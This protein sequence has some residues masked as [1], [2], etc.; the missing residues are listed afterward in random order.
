MKYMLLIYG[1]AELWASFDP[2]DFP[3]VI[4]ATDALHNE[5]RKTGEFIGAYGVSDQVL[6]K[7]VHI[8]NG[9]P[10]VTDGPYIEAKEYIGSFTLIDV[11]SLDRALEIA[12]LDPF[13]QY[14]QVE[15]RP[16]MNESAEEM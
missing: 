11:E 5:L 10:V 15:V 4:A 13:A 9:V 7:T 6:A 16:L 12:A 8:D 2:D 14:G 1:N 3:K